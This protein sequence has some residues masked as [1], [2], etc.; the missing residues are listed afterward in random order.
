MAKCLG[1]SWNSNLLFYILFM[2]KKIQNVRNI[3][4]WFTSF[5]FTGLV[6]YAFLSDKFHSFTAIF[7]DCACLTVLFCEAP[8]SRLHSCLFYCHMLWL[9]GVFGFLLSAQLCS[10]VCC[11]HEVAYSISFQASHPKRRRPFFA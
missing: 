8:F 2:K 9:L 10:Q 3:C 7:S 6:I 4:V 5:C 11:R 1:E